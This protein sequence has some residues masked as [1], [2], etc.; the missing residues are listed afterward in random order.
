[1][2]QADLGVGAEAAVAAV[3]TQGEGVQVVAQVTVE[4]GVEG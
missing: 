4:V 2:I 1:M 3:L